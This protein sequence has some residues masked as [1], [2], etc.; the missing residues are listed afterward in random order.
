MLATLFNCTI[1]EVQN[2]IYNF[3]SFILFSFTLISST[4]HAQHFNFQQTDANHTIII[5][6]AIIG[7]EL[8]QNGVKIGVLTPGGNCAGAVVVEEEFPVGLAG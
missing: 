5:R 2:E 7:D 6:E 3:Y 1:V 4:L 8:L